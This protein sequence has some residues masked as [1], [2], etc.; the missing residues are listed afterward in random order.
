MTALPKLYRMRGISYVRVSSGGKAKA[1]ARV[2]RL[3]NA[4]VLYFLACI[5][6]KLS[7]IM[8]HLP[9]AHTI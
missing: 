2:L 9:G 3:R 4:S 8:A 7:G 1:P 5:S 6:A